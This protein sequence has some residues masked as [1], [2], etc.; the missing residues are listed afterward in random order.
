MYATLGAGFFAMMAF[1]IGYATL[2]GALL[3]A[4]DGNFIASV[5]VLVLGCLVTF[6]CIRT[7]LSHPIYKKRPDA[8]EN[9][10]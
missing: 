3:L 1:F 10:R 9:G 5:A 6:I 4:V 8:H 2:A 7:E